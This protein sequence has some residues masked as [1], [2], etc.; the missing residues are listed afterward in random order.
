MVVR[1][2]WKIILC[3]NMIISVILDFNHQQEITIL[4]YYYITIQYYNITIDLSIC[5]CSY[6]VYSLIYLTYNLIK[7]GRD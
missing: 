2:T 5:A 6:M 4:Q 1:H 3:L 7:E